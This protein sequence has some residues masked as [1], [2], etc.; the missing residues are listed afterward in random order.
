LA[1][2]DYYYYQTDTF[3]EVVIDYCAHPDNPKLHE[4]NCHQFV[5]PLV[6]EYIK[7]GEC[8]GAYPQ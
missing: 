4:G 6:R 1:E 3:D 2:C 7:Y 5:C 8:G